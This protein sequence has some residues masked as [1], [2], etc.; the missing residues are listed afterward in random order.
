MPTEQ[1][2]FRSHDLTLNQ[3]HLTSLSPVIAHQL[4]KSVSQGDGTRTF[5]S[6]PDF[7]IVINSADKTYTVGNYEG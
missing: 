5:I 7:W 2:P 4:V 1:K 6:L 3:H